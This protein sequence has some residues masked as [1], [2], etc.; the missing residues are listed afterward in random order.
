[1]SWL[2]LKTVSEVKS[3][4]GLTR[5]RQPCDR[6]PPPWWI[7][8]CPVTSGL[9]A[10][11][12]ITSTS[13][14]PGTQRQHDNRA[15][16]QQRES[17]SSTA[18]DKLHHGIR[19]ARSPGC[20]YAGAQH[21]RR[22]TGHARQRISRVQNQPQRRSRKNQ[23]DERNQPSTAAGCRS[24]GAQQMTRQRKHFARQSR[25]RVK[26]KQEKQQDFQAAI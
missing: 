26:R 14:A 9:S 21:D 1:M 8:C 18:P 24:E 16:Q 15:A 19:A 13:T 2:Q 17:D 3:V 5:N 25:K 10:T 6:P 11:C 23:Q 4:E 22:S 7:A 12:H 20:R